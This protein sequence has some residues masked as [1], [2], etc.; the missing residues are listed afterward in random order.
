M[1]HSFDALSLT[2]A[3]SRWEREIRWSCQNRSPFSVASAIRRVRKRYRVKPFRILCLALLLALPAMAATNAP[4][5]QGDGVCRFILHDYPLSKAN[6]A[7]INFIVT[8]LLKR[9]ERAFDFTSRTNLRVV[10]RVFGRFDDF[11]DHIH[12]NTDGFGELPSN[13]EVTNLAGV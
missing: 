11:R 4:V 13:M 10:I 6:E 12:A 1:S 3:L 8:D 9:H 5:L 2:P 7:T